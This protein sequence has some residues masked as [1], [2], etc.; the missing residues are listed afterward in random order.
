MTKKDNKGNQEV[1]SEA[2][3]EKKEVPKKE[4]KG[5]KLTKE[6]L[7][8][9]TLEKEAQ[10][11]TIT[12]YSTGQIKIEPLRNVVSRAQAEFVLKKGVDEYHKRDLAHLVAI[13]VIQALGNAQKQQKTFVQ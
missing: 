3:V 9:E 7:A 4:G 11:I 10:K 8:A 1:K 2:E 6:E 12:L 5:K 13:T